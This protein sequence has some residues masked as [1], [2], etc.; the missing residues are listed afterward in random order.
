MRWFLAALLG[1]GVVLPTLATD[2][3]AQSGGNQQDKGYQ[4]GQ[5]SSGFTGQTGNQGSGPN[6][7]TKGNAGGDR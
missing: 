6:S 5:S 7:S 2:S 1:L 4:A 3:F